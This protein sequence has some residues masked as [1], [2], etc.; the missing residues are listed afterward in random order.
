MLEN[1]PGGVRSSPEGSGT[2]NDS[3]AKRRR[4]LPSGA[5]SFV[6]FVGSDSDW[7]GYEICDIQNT[8]AELGDINERLYGVI[9]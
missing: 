6:S 2:K 4:P 7:L 3:H 9:I 5:P 1:S 8:R